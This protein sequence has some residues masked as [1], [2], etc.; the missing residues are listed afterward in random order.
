MVLALAA[1]TF[2]VTLGLGRTA[3]QSVY[4]ALAV[5]VV[6]C[7]CALILATPAA[8]LAALG[9]LAGTG[10]LIKGGAALERLAR[11]D[12]FAFDKTGTLTEGR[13][14]LG[15]IVPRAGT[16]AA[17]VL[18]A[19]ATAEQRSEHL[20]A[21]L[22]VQQAAARGLTPDSVDD[23][24]AHPG[25]GS[26][27]PHRER[28]L[29][30]RY[31]SPARRTGRASAG[32]P[33]RRCWSNSI[34]R[35][36]RFFWWP[37]QGW[38]FGAIGAHDRMRPEAVAVVAEL[39]AS[40]I[41]DIVLLTG[42]RPAAARIV[43]AALGITD[44]QAGLL[45]QQKAEQIE[46]R[47]QQGQRVAMVGDGINDAPALARA[48]VGLALGGT[49]VAAEA[50]DIVFLGDP[51]R[52]LPLLLR[53]AR[54]TV[55]V[56][57]QNILLFAFGVNAVGILATAWL[58]PL[59]APAGWYEQGPLAAVI[60][61]QIGSLAVLLNA[62]RLLWFERR[63]TSPAWRAGLDAVDH[64]VERHLDLH[65]GLHWLS[66][67]GRPVALGAAGLLLLGY[68]LSG[69]IQVGPGEQA[70]VRRFGRPLEEDL[71]PG[72]WWRWPWPIEDVTRIRPDEI[73]QVEIGFRGVPGRSTVPAGLT[74]ASSHG[75]DGVRRVPEEAVMITGD[76]NLVELQATLR[77]TI[78]KPRT[79]L[80]EVCDPETILRAAAESVLRE[81]VASQP[82]HDLLT[83]GAAAWRKRCW[84]GWTGACREA[85]G[86]GLGVRLDGLS[87][88][89][90]H[91]PQ[92]VVP[93]Y[94]EV[95]RAMEAR[96][97]QINQAEA[98]VRYKD[99]ALEQSAQRWQE[100]G[101]AE[102]SLNEAESLALQTV[103]Q[104]EASRLEKVKEAEAGRD[105]FLARLRARGEQPALTD[106]R[107]YWNALGRSLAGR[108]KMVIDADQVPGRR[109]LLLLDPEQ[110]RP[111]LPQLTAPKRN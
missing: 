63:T 38:L 20:L 76:G 34:P 3:R 57:R 105:V 61:H 31:S 51:L 23:F 4:P 21:R 33:W 52:H 6:A 90:L 2:L 101:P 56:I 39:R 8:I 27:R 45:P 110:F 5:L 106:F 66:H 83:R 16:T 111:V 89:D 86:Q 44:V 42:D 55:R 15:D 17:R 25:S 22:I 60:Y 98:E 97:R 93:A 104:A 62:L 46:A 47:R 11:V 85:G 102:L 72:L 64:W 40:G 100:G 58:W 12:V 96:D 14:E 53:L 18:H 75:D 54:Q 79:Y 95:T 81:T 24:L 103:R 107:L 49:D 13:L 43:A 37:V 30:G 77:Y 59:L 35:D 74:W 7:P 19:A 29:G 67:H 9:R 91:P 78:A 84:P 71:G 82:F 80:F 99:R 10:I 70:V 92:E 36:K 32:G 73:R 88:H 65:E 69:L 94:H 109:H 1:A 41:A 26:H 28:D 87:L 50:G 48:D 68:G 108:D